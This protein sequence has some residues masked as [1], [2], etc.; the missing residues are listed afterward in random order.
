MRLV[1]LFSATILARAIN[2]EAYLEFISKTGDGIFLMAF[3]AMAFDAIEVW[4]RF[5]S[6]P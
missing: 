6:K 1:I 5:R 3:Y 4:Q 2:Y